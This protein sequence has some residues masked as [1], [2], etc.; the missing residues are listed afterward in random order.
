MYLKDLYNQL[1]YH[2]LRNQHDTCKDMGNESKS[3][4]QQRLKDYPPSLHTVDPDT[5]VET[6]R[7]DSRRYIHVEGE[8]GGHFRDCTFEVRFDPQGQRLEHGWIG[9]GCS[10]FWEPFT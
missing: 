2:F 4:Y 10:F 9:R 1:D 3:C 5:G 8:T 6:F 7:W